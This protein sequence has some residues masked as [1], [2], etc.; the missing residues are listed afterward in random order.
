MP[1]SRLEA[2][3]DGVMAIII[4]IMVLEIH[5]PEQATLAA[6]RALQPTVLAYL[7]SFVI[8]AIYWNN[9]HALLRATRVIDG[10]VMWAN[11]HLLFW[12]S[13]VPVV[14]AWVGEAHEQSLPAA[15]YGFVSLMSGIAYMILVLSIIRANP[16]SAIVQAIGDDAKGKVSVALFGT[17]IVLDFV[18]PWLA[19]AC[20]AL[21]SALWFI[22]D[23][24]LDSIEE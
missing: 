19:Y 21:V 3:S 2:F 13:L 1:T 12:L 17:G 6:L 10:R 14:T 7:L 20:Y 11:M 4:T 18:G 5:P 24:R 16:G 9:H 22:P 8:I 15:A 23:R